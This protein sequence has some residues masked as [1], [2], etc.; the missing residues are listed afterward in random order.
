MN[1]DPYVIVACGVAFG[2]VILSIGGAIR[3]ARERAR[4]TPIS[5]VPERLGEPDMH[6]AL[7]R[8]LHSEIGRSYGPK[9][10]DGV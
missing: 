8:R 2:V 1:L 6:G 3:L 9:R 4:E 7:M 10:R 5:P